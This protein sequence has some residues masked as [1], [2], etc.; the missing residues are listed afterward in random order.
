[1]GSA[2]SIKN[3]LKVAKEFLNGEGC[4]IYNEDAKQRFRPPRVVLAYQKGLTKEII[5]RL[6]RLANPKLV[7][8]I[9]VAGSSGMR[10]GEIVQ[11]KLSKLILVHQNESP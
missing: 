11:Q 3:Y 6:V 4:K 2:V 1:M 9:L 7:A 5:N 10:L 8:C